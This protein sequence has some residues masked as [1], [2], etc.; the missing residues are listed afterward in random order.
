MTN[1]RIGFGYDFHRL[2]PGLNLILGSVEIPHFKGVVAH[3]DGDILIHALIDALLG[4]AAYGDLGTFFPS[5]DES[6]RDISSVLMLEEI[7][8]KLREDNYKIVN[9]DLTYVGQTPNL[10][11]YKDRIRENLSEIIKIDKTAISCKAT[12]TDGLGFEGNLAGV[13]SYCAVLIQR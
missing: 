7:L 9:I 11:D 4:A 13:S 1:L 12:T 8:K 6:F 2:K 5:N 3:S 10:K